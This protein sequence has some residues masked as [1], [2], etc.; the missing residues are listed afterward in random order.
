M[1]H[2]RD[3]RKLDVH[4]LPNARKISKEETEEYLEV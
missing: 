2:I 4:W 3:E 1:E